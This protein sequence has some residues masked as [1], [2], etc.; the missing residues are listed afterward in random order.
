VALRGIDD[1]Q[2]GHSRVV[3]LLASPQAGGSG[4]IDESHQQEDGKGHNDE[5][6]HAC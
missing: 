4:A 3:A 6:D 1:T 2:K 5:V